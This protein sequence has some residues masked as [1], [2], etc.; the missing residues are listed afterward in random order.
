MSLVK[1][2]I[3]GFV[4]DKKQNVLIPTNVIEK[5][6]QVKLN[7]KKHKKQLHFEKRLDELERKVRWLEQCQGI[8]SQTN[9]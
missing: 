5:I 3:P 4:K 9:R 8:G 1:T 2:N 7:R 6:E